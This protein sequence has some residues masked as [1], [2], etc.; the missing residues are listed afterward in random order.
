M[1]LSN[2]PEREPCF[3]SVLCT[4][5]ATMMNLH[6]LSID[7]EQME[8]GKKESNRAEGGNG[9]RSEGGPGEDKCSE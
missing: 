7:I 3:S 8:G 9:I 5:A 1:K 6:L 4:V 2:S